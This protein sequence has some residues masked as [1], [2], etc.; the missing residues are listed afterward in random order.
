M[1]K[2]SLLY[3]EK[4]FAMR[5]ETI[6]FIE[7]HLIDQIEGLLQKTTQPDQLA[8]LK[9]RA[10]KIRDE[11]GGINTK[12]FQKLRA[13]I[14]TGG[15]M[16]E[17]FKDM[18]NEYVDLNSYS[19]EHLKEGYDNLDLFINGLMPLQIIPEQTKDLEPEMVYYQ[20]TP[21]RIVFN[22]VEI[23]HLTKEDVFF[24]LGSGLGQVAILVNLLTGI[25]VKGVE[26]ESA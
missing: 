6:D 2:N 1:E 10:E 18:V 11:L 9:Y 24:D 17:K 23:S 13:N 22:L 20:K 15:Y 26:F 12:L 21:A 4:N 7:F 16:G 5:V 19:D 8:L 14:L 3:E 25:T